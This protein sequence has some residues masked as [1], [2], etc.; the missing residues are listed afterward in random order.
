MLYPWP[1]SDP[2][3]Q[4]ALDIALDYLEKTEQPIAFRETQWV[5]AGVIWEAWKCGTRHRIK[6]AN[7]AIVAIESQPRMRKPGFARVFQR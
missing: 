6:L 7:H 4:E 1:V 2:V 5:C 3:L